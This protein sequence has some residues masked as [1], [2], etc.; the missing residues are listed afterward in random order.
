MQ[1][2]LIVDKGACSKAGRKQVNQDA[3]GG[4]VPE[5][6]ALSSKGAAF[7]IADGISSS[8]VSDQ[9]SRIAITRFLEDYYHTPIEWS[10]K[11]SVQH[12]LLAINSWLNAQTFRSPHRFDKNRGFV[13][14]FSGLVI[15]SRMVHIFHLGDTRIY[16]VRTG[17][18]EQL[19]EDHRFWGEED[20]SY[21]A[22]ALGMS[23]HLEIDYT[24]HEAKVGD[25]YL[26]MSD[27]VYDHLKSDDILA[28]LNSD[29]DLDQVCQQWV[30]LAYQRGSA[31]NLTAIAVRLLQLPDHDVASLYQA[32]SALPLPPALE[33][34]KQFEGY[35]ILRVLH[36][37]HRSQVYLARDTSTGNQVVLKVPATDLAASAET[38]E[39]FYLEEWIARRIQHRHVL[40]PFAS[41]RQRQSLY[42]VMEYVPGQTLQ[43]WM[44]DHPQPSLEM[45]RHIVEQL[46]NALEAFHR[47]EMV[48]QDL[49]P[50]NILID[51]DGKI[52][53]ID[54]GAVSVAGLDEMY[55]HTQTW[56]LLGS[57]QYSAPEQ[58]FGQPGSVQSDLFALGCIT[59]QLLT[60]KLPYG[61]EV[62]KIKHGD[63]RLRLY[64]RDIR[65]EQPDFPAWMDQAI[66]RAVHPYAEKRYPSL[67]EFVFDLRTPNPAFNRHS[68]PALLQRHPL[69]FW[70]G[71]S[72]F[73]ACVVFVLL[74]ML[75]NQK[76][77]EHAPILSKPHKSSAVQL[78]TRLSA[79]L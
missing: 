36:Q 49:Q 47:L 46:A 12:V 8:D 67:S 62:A 72:F 64:Y 61:T 79:K 30:A 40:R 24:S 9:A 59:Y 5:A 13:C 28:L 78:T 77:A 70:R 32:L 50:A 2:Q 4:R 41:E 55:S 17:H 38:L 15:K 23:P 29:T 66:A 57:V 48:Y 31:D 65:Y 11:S 10:V 18:L 20:R 37:S 27:G 53:L 52:T 76:H 73:L 6:P 54:F 19:T 21:L 14:T 34:G 68:H 3:E 58:F 56:G 69:G 60:G 25:I 39:R 45:V 44:L 51:E 33:E 74:G 35:L 26:L 42:S 75:A 43:Q 1:K 71:L 63:D 22:R 7:A 16:R